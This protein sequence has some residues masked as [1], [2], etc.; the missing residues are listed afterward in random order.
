[1]KINNIWKKIERNEGIYLPTLKKVPIISKNTKICLMGSCFA[2]EIGW[3]L[4]EN[5]INIGKVEY[6]TEMK[7]VSYPWGTFFSPQNMLDIIELSLF[8]KSDEFFDEKTFIR[9]PKKLIGNHYNKTTQANEDEDHK[10]INLFLKARLETKNYEKA[11]N[12]IKNKIQFFKK[13]ILDADVIIITLGLIETWIDKDKNKA[14]HSF[15]GNA[16]KKE[17]I[18]N[19]AIFKQLNLEEV[20][21]CLKIIINTIN[22]ESKKKIIFTVSPIPLNFTFT[23]KDIVIAN[24]YSKSLL[25]TAVEKFIND[26]DIYYFPSFEIVQDCIGWPNAFKD[27]K[28][29][30]KV[31][32][33]KNFIAPK[34]IESFT[35]FERFDL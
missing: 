25:R 7:H 29:H 12:E 3:V 22:S 13:S 2:D 26:N 21:H 16:L 11:K 1:M 9:V 6:N 30:V 35:D 19:K 5:K 33:F 18:E 15:H 8:D 24:K 27:D 32:I 14:W 4:A 20:C 23:N 28:R 10:L 34:F 17:S 31:E